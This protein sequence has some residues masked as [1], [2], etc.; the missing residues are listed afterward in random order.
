MNKFCEITGFDP[1]HGFV[2]PIRAEPLLECKEVEDLF[3]KLPDYIMSEGIRDAVSGLQPIAIPTD[4]I[5]MR[6]LFVMLSFISHVFIRGAI[7]YNNGVDVLPKKLA[8]PLVELAEKVGVM[9]IGSYASTTQFNVLPFTSNT[10]D[11]DIV[12][13]GSATGLGDEVWFY[14]SG[15]I[16]ERLSCEY[17]E[18]VLGVHEA[19]NAN[20]KNGAYNGLLKILN[21][22]KQFKPKLMR[23]RE[24]CRVEQFYGV[25]RKYLAGWKNDCQFTNGVEYEGFGRMVLPGA[26]AAQSP[27][28]QLVD[29]TLGIGHKGDFAQ[30]MYECV[31]AGDRRVLD[32]FKATPSLHDIVHT[33]KDPA[34]TEI[35]EKILQSL[36]EFRDE[37]LKIVAQYIL[38]PASLSHASTTGTGGSDPQSFLV[39]YKQ[40]TMNANIY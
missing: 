2:H 7:N 32:Y 25:I 1:V 20:D 39:S 23:L 30:L 38:K 29:I 17:I 11:D 9:P 13:M 34:C 19:F 8:T 12:I 4:I 10:S 36:Y 26:T 21:I 16:I 35:Y 6:R 24:K 37:H 3:A 27:F 31:P 5:C 33:L 14:K 15:L 22:T 40:D 28:I 18:G